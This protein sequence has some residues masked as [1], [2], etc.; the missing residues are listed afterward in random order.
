MTTKKGRK[1]MV[2]FGLLPKDLERLDK[3]IKRQRFETNR[4]AMCREAVLEF[5]DREERPK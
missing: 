2:A 3:L 5:L 1:M 4:A